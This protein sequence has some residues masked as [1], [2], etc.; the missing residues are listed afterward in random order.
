MAGRSIRSILLGG[1]ACLAMTLAGVVWARST[2]SQPGSTDVPPAEQVLREV[3]QKQPQAEPLLPVEPGLPVRA[4]RQPATTQTAS[5][6]QPEG[7]LLP[8][9]YI[10][11]ER[12]GR[13]VREGAW[14]CLVFEGA[15]QS[16][17][18]SRSIRLLPNRLLE[19]MEVASA[20]GTRPILFIVTGEV[21]EYRGAN[22][23]LVRHVLIKRDMGNLS[24]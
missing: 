7:R 14:W 6:S 20:G 5:G 8:D 3:L 24:K 10:L 18:Q 1:S 11:V 9:G 4:A 13:L 15:G 12:T 2:A 16:I 23:L 21:T 22:Y 19:I 17:G